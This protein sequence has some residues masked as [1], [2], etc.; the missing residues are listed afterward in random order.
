MSK[1]RIFRAQSSAGF[2]AAFTAAWN[3]ARAS[4]PEGGFELV[5]RKL[6]DKRSLD[7]NKRYW[8]LLREV[9]AAVWVEGRSYPDTVWH[10]Q[11]R[12]WFIGCNEVV[13]PDGST[14]MHG[15]STT[16]LSVDEFGQYMTQI[17]A[18]CAEQGFP[19]MECAA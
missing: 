17:E 11:F 7:Q 2:R 18:W 15:I 6:K 14:E 3:L 4:F 1:E 10:E 8:A 5:I 12:R 13:L 19:V 9:S 16:T